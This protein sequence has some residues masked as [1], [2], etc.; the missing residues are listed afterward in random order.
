MCCAPCAIKDK[1]GEKSK[2]LAEATQTGKRSRSKQCSHVK[3][4]VLQV[5]RLV[6]YE[7]KRE[8]AV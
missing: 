3:H 6:T 2:I 7:R 4:W 5:V 8:M 1:S